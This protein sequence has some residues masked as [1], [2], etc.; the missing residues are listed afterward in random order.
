MEQYTDDGI[1]LKFWNIGLAEFHIN[2]RPKRNDTTDT[3]ESRILTMACTRKWRPKILEI[4][5]HYGNTTSNIARVIKLLRGEFVTV[6]VVAPPS[7]TFLK[8]KR[9]MSD[10]KKR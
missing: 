6:D 2:Y 4:G 5:T 8:C 10:L 1:G 3:V 9:E 7:F